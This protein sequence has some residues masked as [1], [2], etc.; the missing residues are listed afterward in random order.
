MIG[1]IILVIIGKKFYELA[2][3]YE[4]SKW[5]ITVLGIVSYYSGVFVFGIILAAIL[6]AMESN[7]METTDRLSLALIELPS[8]GLSSYLLFMFLQ[9]KWEKEKPQ[10]DNVIN[11]IGNKE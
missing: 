1:I 8:G 2:G 5:G 10:L 11:Q 3:E 6:I 9:K 7:W 4:K